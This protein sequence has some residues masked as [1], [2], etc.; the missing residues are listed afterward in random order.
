MFSMPEGLLG[1]SN[2]L[3]NSSDDMNQQRVF[4]IERFRPWTTFE[5][6]PLLQPGLGVQPT[7][8]NK[9]SL[10]PLELTFIAYRGRCNAYAGALRDV[11]NQ[12]LPPPLASHKAP[13]SKRNT[14]VGSCLNC[15]YGADMCLTV[16]SDSCLR[17]DKSMCLTSPHCSL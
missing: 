10:V 7:Q 14:N 17:C 6:S 3:F 5:K 11:T 1:P 13:K 4:A 2:R 16:I 12:G 8:Q 9:A 15:G